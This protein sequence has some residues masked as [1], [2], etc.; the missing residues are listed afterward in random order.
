MWVK[1]DFLS[2]AFTAVTAA[3]ARGEVT[4]MVRDDGPVGLDGVVVVFDEPSA[5]IVAAALEPP[6]PER[7]SPRRLEA[8]ATPHRSCLG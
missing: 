6:S 7:P 4:L 2:R 8:L 3:A 5:D 1:N